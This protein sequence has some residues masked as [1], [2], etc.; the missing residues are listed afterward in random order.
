M[1]PET[2]TQPQ[3]PRAGRQRALSP[4]GSAGRRR[5]HGLVLPHLPSPGAS[6]HPPLTLPGLS[7]KPTGL[8]VPAGPSLGAARRPVRRPPGLVLGSG[9]VTMDSHYLPGAGR[10]P[11]GLPADLHSHPMRSTFSAIRRTQGPASRAAS[12]KPFRSPPWP[13]GAL[14]G[15]S[16]QFTGG[17]ACQPARLLR[18]LL[19]C[20]MLH[21]W[22][23][24]AP[25]SPLW[26]WT[27]PSRLSCR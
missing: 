11:D 19:A 27:G 26:G 1:A 10:A 17:Q 24:K 25:Y 21:S 18:G 4:P 5:F 16:N 2:P 9:L 3:V 6:G 20:G 8:T 14:A 12:P 13:V 15:N 22:P 7:P 23:T